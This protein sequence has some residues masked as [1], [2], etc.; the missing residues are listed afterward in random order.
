[1]SYET[2]PYLVAI[3]TVYIGLC[4]GLIAQKHGKNPLLYG[5]LSITPL[6]FIVLGIWAF[7]SYENE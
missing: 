2:S 4:A 7:S 5:F 6:I 1:M 3:L